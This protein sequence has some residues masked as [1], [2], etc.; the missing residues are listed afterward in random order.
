MLLCPNCRLYRS[1]QRVPFTRSAVVAAGDSR[2]FFAST[3]FPNAFDCHF[4]TWKVSVPITLSF[5]A[6]TLLTT[7]EEAKKMR[8]EKADEESTTT[9]ISTV[10]SDLSVSALESGSVRSLDAKREPDVKA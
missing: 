9:S 7:R 4:L 6:A 1:L 8:V 10:P 2:D 3:W 5:V